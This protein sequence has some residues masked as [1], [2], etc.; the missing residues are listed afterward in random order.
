MLGADVARAVREPGDITSGPRQAFHEASADRVADGPHDDGDVGG[1]FLR[2]AGCGR[3]LCH[4]DVHFEIYQLGRKTWKALVFPFGKAPFDDQVLSIDVAE[5]AQARPQCLRCVT[6][7]SGGPQE[8]HAPD[9]ALLLSERAERRCECACAKRDDQFAAIV[10]SPSLQLCAPIMLAYAKDSRLKSIYRGNTIELLLATM[11]TPSKL[12]RVVVRR[13]G[14]CSHP[15]R[16]FPANV[17]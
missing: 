4:D 8:T 11:R 13:L 15:S 2:C 5:F 10:H 14:C 9:F 1:R 7:S 17:R 3:A 6:G 16:R 12:W